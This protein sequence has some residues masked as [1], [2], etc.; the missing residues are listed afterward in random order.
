MQEYKI[1]TSNQQVQL[2]KLKKEMDNL[3]KEYKNTNV[4][5]DFI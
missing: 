5:L 3:V 4:N 1:E 2:D